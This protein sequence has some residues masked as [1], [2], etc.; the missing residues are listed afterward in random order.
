VPDT[1]AV[2]V[3]LRAR[4]TA[5]F[6][7]ATAVVLAAVGLFVFLQFSAGVTRATDDGLLK[8]QQ[9]V[10][11]LLREGEGPARLEAESGERLLQLYRFDGSVVASSR[12]L[13]G[14]RLVLPA[15]V[16]RAAES[17]ISL[18]RERIADGDEARVRAFAVARPRI[19]VAIGESLQRD[20]DLRLR[21]AIALAIALPGALVLASYLGYRVAGAA[22]KSV[23]RMRVQ[24]ARITESDLSRRLP[25][26]QTGDELERLSVTF[27]ALLDR[28]SRAVEH[29][30]RL[31]SEASHELRTP[32]S[33]LRAELEVATDPA[34]TPDQLRATVGSALEETRRLSRLADDLLVL[35]RADQGRLPL[36]L[37]PLDVADVLAEA[38]R[39]HGAATAAAGRELTTGVD[40]PG[41]AVVLADASRVMQA[42][43][44]LIANAL[45]H[46]IGRIEV[47]ATTAPDDRIAISVSDEG[48]GIPGALVDRAFERFS[49]GDP[50]HGG[51]GSGL[52]LAIV[53]AIASA[54]GGAVRAQDGAVILELPAA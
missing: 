41:G 7:A 13:E 8:R 3:S 11:N 48:P 46:G 27:N 19:V 24:A 35:A 33:V 45:D 4:L 51:A 47:R 16:R 15:D 49:Q 22:L 32:L 18:E 38:A 21:L 37:E 36:R 29:E 50:S 30:R 34:R 40:I 44:N 12:A 20:H 39:R 54:H 25:V 43:D 23:E 5:A 52:G 53:D 6:A 10:L 28:L 9:A 26:P 14:T 17:P 2:P 42:L 31:V 1:Q